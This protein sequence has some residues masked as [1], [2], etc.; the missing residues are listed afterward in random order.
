MPTTGG[1]SG[2]TTRA[3]FGGMTT[4]YE[5]D[6]MSTKLNDGYGQIAPKRAL[7]VNF[8]NLEVVFT[9]CARPGPLG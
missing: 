4:P 7:D 1:L 3:R 8:S 2:L 9:S 6:Y 5:G